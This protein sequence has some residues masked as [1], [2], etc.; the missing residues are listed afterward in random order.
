MSRNMLEI[1]ENTKSNL[2][3]DLMRCMHKL[4]KETHSISDGR[5]WNS[6]VN[7]L[8]HKLAIDTNIDK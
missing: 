5:T 6:Q 8:S 4:A 1:G 2:P 7:K 3:I